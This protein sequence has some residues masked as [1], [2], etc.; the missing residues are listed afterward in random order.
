VPAIIIRII[1][2]AVAIVSIVLLYKTVAIKSSISILKEA[3]LG[4]SIG[5]EDAPYTIVEF[6]DYKCNFCRELHPEMEIL[7]RNNPDIKIVFR[8]MPA[9]GAPSMPAIQLA[10]AAG[11]QGKYEQVHN[12]LMSDDIEVNDAFIAEIARTNNLDHE[13]LK[14]DMKGEEIGRFLLTNIDAAERLDV[15]ATPTFLVGEIIYKPD[16]FTP[17]E[18]DFLKLISEAYQQ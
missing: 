10:L 15:K 14:K 5:E 3:P 7:V 6:V 13:K 18:D 9:F 4:N 11:M 2:I 1:Y 8:H 12:R 17:T 16:G